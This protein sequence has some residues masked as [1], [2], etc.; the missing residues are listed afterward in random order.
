MSEAAERLREA[1]QDI[2]FED[3]KNSTG[4]TGMTIAGNGAAELGALMCDQW[5]T[6]GGVVPD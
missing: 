1:L 2:F 3:G 4:H 6:R 5:K